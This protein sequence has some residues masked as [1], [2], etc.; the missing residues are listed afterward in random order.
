M[1]TQVIPFTGSAEEELKR[2]Y[3]ELQIGDLVS[4]LR[5]GNLPDQVQALVV[6]LTTTILDLFG[7]G[8]PT[9]GLDPIS[10]LK[11]AHVTSTFQGSCVSVGCSACIVC[12]TRTMRRT[13]RFT[14]P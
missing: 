6:P 3:D 2:L 7:T 4:A 5:G 14:R 8:T 10:T 1:D 11:S 12:S 13:S 9:I